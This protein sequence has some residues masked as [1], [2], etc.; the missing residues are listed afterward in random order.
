MVHPSIAIAVLVVGVIGKSL[1]ESGLIAMLRGCPQA[2]T[3]FVEAFAVVP[4]LAC[5]ET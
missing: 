1:D 5:G 2:W 3:T 4:Q